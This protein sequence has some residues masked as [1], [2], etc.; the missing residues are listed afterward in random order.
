MAGDERSAEDGAAPLRPPRP[1]RRP[2]SGII[3]LAAWGRD[4]SGM[5][6]G[7]CRAVCGLEYEL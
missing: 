1:A 3:R 7:A 4:E 6:N 5:H 2:V